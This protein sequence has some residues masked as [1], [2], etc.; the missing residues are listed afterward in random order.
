[1]GGWW[2]LIKVVLELT[3]TPLVQPKK[4]GSDCFKS[5]WV[6]LL[7]KEHIC[8]MLSSLFTRFLHWND[9]KQKKILWKNCSNKEALPW[10]S[11]DPTQLTKFENQKGRREIFPQSPMLEAQTQFPPRSPNFPEKKRRNGL[12]TLAH[13]RKA[14]KKEAL[15]FY[16]CGGPKRRFFRKNSPNPG[17]T[18]EK[19]MPAA[20]ILLK[21]MKF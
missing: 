10:P 2:R 13:T 1:M 17:L 7:T 9:D 8:D 19:M 5:P 4:H 16:G 12:R 15:K 6:R 3:D 20:L 14:G 21:G 11:G 18:G